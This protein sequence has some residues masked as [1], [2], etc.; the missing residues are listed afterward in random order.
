MKIMS[1]TFKPLLLVVFA[2]IAI[3]G[4]SKE[5]TIFSS[6]QLEAAMKVDLSD[7]VL[8][9]MDGSLI[10]SSTSNATATLSSV[11]DCINSFATEPLTATEASSLTIM[12]EEELLAMDVYAS[13]YALYNMPVFN[14]ISKSEFQHSTAV[15]ALLD[16]YGLTDIAADHVTGVFVNK[17]I[18]NLYN[19]LLAKGSVSL[20]DALNVGA[21]IEDLDIQDLKDHMEKDVDNADIL[22]VYNNLQKGSRNHMRAFYRLLQLRGITYTPQYI[23]MDYLTQIVNGPHESGGGCQ[24]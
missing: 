8:N 23:S 17:D 19:S 20:N 7:S 5:N 4:C 10:A 22:F 3:T 13:M 2:I 24:N 14:N 1:Q 21:T 15:K 9:G 6:Q 11:Y 18:Q 12:R 16:K